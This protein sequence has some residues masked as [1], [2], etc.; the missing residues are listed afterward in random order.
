MLTYTGTLFF[1]APEMFYGG[2]YNEKVD[3]WAAGVTLYYAI[4]GK[5]PFESAY[6]S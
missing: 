3:L 2:G 1:R 6:H 5:T 4:I